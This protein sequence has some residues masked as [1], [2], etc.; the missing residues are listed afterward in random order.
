MEQTAVHPHRGTLL[1]TVFGPGWGW[2]SW[3]GQPFTYGGVP[4]RISGPSP[5]PWCQQPHHAPIQALKVLRVPAGE[6]SL[7]TGKH[8]LCTELRHHASDVSSYVSGETRV[9]CLL[10]VH[11]VATDYILWVSRC[12]A[13][14]LGGGMASTVVAQRHL[15]LT[16]WH[17]G[18]GQSCLSGRT[19]VGW[20]FVWLVARRHPG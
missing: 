18:Q 9:T 17:F 7:D 2:K 14:S 19:S 1:W 13:L 16:L 11:R 4:G 6:D 3:F 5:E 20:W 10:T 8:G 15:W 12:A